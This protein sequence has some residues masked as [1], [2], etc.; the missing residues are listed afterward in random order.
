MLPRMNK[1]LP[2]FRESSDCSLMV[3]VSMHSILSL[4]S[5]KNLHKKKPKVRI[6]I[7]NEGEYVKMKR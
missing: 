6:N 5:K 4:Q 7:S 1:M 3:V 2:T